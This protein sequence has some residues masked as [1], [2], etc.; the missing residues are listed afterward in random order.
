MAANP[1]GTDVRCVFDADTLWTAT[2]GLQAVEQDLIHRLLTDNVLGPGGDGWGY[3]VR[4]ILGMPTRAIPGLQPV[5]V[6]VLT[7]DERV[8]TA[9]VT[10]TAT[11]TNGLADVILD[12]TCVLFTGKT[13]RYIKSI[14]DLTAGDIEA[15]A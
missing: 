11:T 1:Y 7:R 4:R 9:D 13:F 14:R 6:E 3:D 10:L 12:V 8:R 5:L 2:T 15:Q